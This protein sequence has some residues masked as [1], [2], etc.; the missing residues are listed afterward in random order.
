MDPADPP[1]TKAATGW[2]ILEVPDLDGDGTREL[3]AVSRFDG[4]NPD[5]RADIDPLGAGAALRGCALGQGRPSA[6]V[7]VTVDLPEYKFGRIWTPRWWG[8]GP[9]GWP[10][11]AVPLGGRHPQG[12][13]ADLAVSR[14]HPP[15]MHVLEAL[16][17]TRAEPR[18]WG[19]R[20]RASPT[21]TVTA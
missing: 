15:V 1:E 10:M 11:L 14:L 13:E 16:D 21:W 7:L 4:R 17:R 6:L 3:V 8:R 9:D 5:P 12:T 18:S 20:G 2:S 19:C